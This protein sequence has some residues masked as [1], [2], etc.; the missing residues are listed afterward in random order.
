VTGSSRRPPPRRRFHR[1]DFFGRIAG[2]G[3]RVGA[4]GSGSGSPPS[5]SFRACS[6]S[7]PSFSCALSLR[8]PFFSFS[9]FSFSFF[10]FLL[11]GL[12]LGRPRVSLHL[13]LF[14]A[15]A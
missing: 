9:F 1:R 11:G 14:S 15:S 5:A 13:D 2:L 3:L 10:L 4:V 7:L 6:S 8:V 12:R